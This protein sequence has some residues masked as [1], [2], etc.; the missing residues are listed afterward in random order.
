VKLRLL[1]LAIDAF[2][3]AGY[4]TIGM[5]HF[6]LPHDDLAQAT[7]HGTLHRN[8]MGYTVQSASDLVALGISGIGDVHGA[9]AQNL[10]KLPE[11]AAA[12]AD[13]RFPIARGYALDQDDLLRR[14]VIT[15]L[16]CD[17]RLDIRDVERRFGISFANTFAVELAELTGRGPYRTDGLLTLTRDAIELTALGRMFVRNVCM[18]FDR[19]LRRRS[20]PE[21]PVFSRT[22]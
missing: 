9:F 8:F 13:R 22:V 4:R 2:T 15:R 20:G 17:A 7:V 18:V 21:R 11:Y 6:A 5:D 1:A 10:K 19:H 14:H 12:L 16:M 3:R